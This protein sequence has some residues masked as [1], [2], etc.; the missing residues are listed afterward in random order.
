[1][2]EGPW[3]THVSELMAAFDKVQ[4]A[5]PSVSGTTQ[6]TENKQAFLTWGTAFVKAYP[7]VA[8]IWNSVI[9]LAVPG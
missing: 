4:Q 2:P 9:S 7:V 8:P 5:Y 3:A 6:A 1:M